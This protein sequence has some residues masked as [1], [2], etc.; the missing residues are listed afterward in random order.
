M[1][2]SDLTSIADFAEG[3][4]EV[5]AVGTDPISD[6]LS[7]WLLHLHRKDALGLVVLQIRILFVVRWIRGE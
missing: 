3:E 7:Q 1:L 4:V 2:A 6:S 5:F